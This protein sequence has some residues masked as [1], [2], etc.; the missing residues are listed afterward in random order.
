MWQAA[1]LKRPLLTVNT[2]RTLIVYART[3]HAVRSARFIYRM[4]FINA[5]PQVSSQVLARSRKVKVIKNNLLA[6]IK[7]SVFSYNFIIIHI[8]NILNFNDLLL[9]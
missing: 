7:I 9:L 6:R 2:L 3:L 5:T 4:L 8:C 1:C